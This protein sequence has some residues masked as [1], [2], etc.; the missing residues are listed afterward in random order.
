MLNTNAISYGH[1]MLQFTK[2]KILHFTRKNATFF[3]DKTSL[4]P[5][6]MSLE[7]FIQNINIHKV[8]DAT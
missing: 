1:K 8:K 4:Q 7:P 2:T 3:E 5:D 6:K